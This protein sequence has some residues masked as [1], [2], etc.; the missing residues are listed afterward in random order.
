MRSSTV[1]FCI[2]CISLSKVFS[3]FTL[4]NPKTINAD[5]DSSF[6]VLFV[7]GDFSSQF[8]YFVMQV[9]NNTLGCLSTYAFDTLYRFSVVA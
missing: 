1:G 2:F 5:N 7:T 6:N 9:N 3:I 8:I 4:L